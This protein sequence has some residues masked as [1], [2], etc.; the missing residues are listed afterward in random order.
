M[1]QVKS[2]KE[3]FVW[4][5]LGTV[6]S[7]AISVILLLVV[8]RLLSNQE[9][10]LFS[11]AYAL[12]NLFV[13]IAQFQVRDYQATDVAEKFTFSQYFGTRI[14]TIFLMIIVVSVY[15]HFINADSEKALCILFACLY[16]GSDALSDVFQGFFQQKARLDLA[17]QSLFYRNT[18]VMLVFTVVAYSFNNLIFALLAMLIVSYLFVFWFDI[19][20]VFRFTKLVLSEIKWMKIKQILLDCL[21]L[22]VNAFL[23]VTIYNQ[24][25]YALNTFFEKG[26][27]ETGVQKDFNILFMPVF[28]LN[29]LLILFR[30]MI[31]QLAV[32][33]SQ[34][35]VKEFKHQQLRI[36]QLMLVLSV[37]V[38]LSGITLGIPVLNIVYGTQLEQYR[39]AF[40]IMLFGGLASTFATICDNMLIVLRKQKYLVV[41]FALSCLVS[42]LI[43]N[44]LV[45]RYLVVGAAISFFVSMW[46]WFGMTLGIYLFLNRRTKDMQFK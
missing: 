16:R 29:I 14:V 32:F 22:F 40:I 31:T 3:I 36:V 9:A 20:K 12:A 25:K 38:L 45:E 28:A 4:N 13:I 2:Q 43:S 17:G 10:D 21:P 35:K 39:M 6:S 46:I 23:L 30:P 34:G 41:S 42:I 5:L 8:S 44:P 18:L 24:P 19:P 27:I 15:I 11:F 33:H 37:V 7:A 1:L 26:L